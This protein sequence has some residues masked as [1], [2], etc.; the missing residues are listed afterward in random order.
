[1][2][3]YRHSLAVGLHEM[4]EALLCKNDGIT[5]AEVD[6]FDFAYAGDGE[7]GGDPLAPYNRQHQ[8]ATCIEALFI[9]AF[10]LNWAAYEEAVDA[11]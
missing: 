10:R 4:V 8:F 1:M 11:L 5:E 6:G 9:H 7:P 3:D 2:A